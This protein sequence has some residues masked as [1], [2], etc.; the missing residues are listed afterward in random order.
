MRH[1]TTTLN[2][3]NTLGHDEDAAWHL[4]N[5]RLRPV[6]LRSALRVGLDHGEAE[7]VAQTTLLAVLTGLRRG[8]FDPGRGRFRSWMYTIAR[9]KIVDLQRAAHRRRAARRDVARSEMDEVDLDRIWIEEFERNLL[10]RAFDELSAS[11][12]RSTT[13]EAFELVCIQERS[14]DEAA[15]TVG[16]SVE[17]V[18]VAK[19]RCLARLRQIAER[20]RHEDEHDL[21]C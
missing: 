20:L 4:I 16:M 10:R 21:V 1:T 14:A 19:H 12:V 17:Q 11:G 18:Y 15:R 6:V 9:G 3:L 13:L 7:D 8:Q 5:E 2:I